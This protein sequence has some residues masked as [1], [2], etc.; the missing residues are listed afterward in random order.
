MK[1]VCKIIYFWQFDAVTFVVSLSSLA[2]LL[3]IDTL[4]YSNARITMNIGLTTK[5]TCINISLLFV[6]RAGF[7][8]RQL[9][10]YFLLLVVLDLSIILFLCQE[11]IYLLMFYFK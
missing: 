8:N 6:N 9:H 10:T 7:L 2:F 1:L 3:V 11:K 5:P 4:L